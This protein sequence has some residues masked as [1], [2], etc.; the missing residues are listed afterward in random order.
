MGKDQEDNIYRKCLSDKFPDIKQED[1]LECTNQIYK[2]RIK[3][4]GY[5]FTNI[6]ETIL[7][8]LH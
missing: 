2:D 1:Y 7:S 3:S 8:D 6:A 5:Q 4:L